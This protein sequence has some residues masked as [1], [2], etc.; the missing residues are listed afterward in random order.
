MELQALSD[1]TLVSCSA[2]YKIFTLAFQIYTLFTLLSMKYLLVMLTI[3]DIY[4][5]LCFPAASQGDCLELSPNREEGCESRE[6]LGWAIRRQKQD[7]SAI[8]ARC[9]IGRGGTLTTR[10]GEK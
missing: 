9:S 3:H 4:A 8:Q 6:S 2:A 7:C 5:A 1:S 10:P